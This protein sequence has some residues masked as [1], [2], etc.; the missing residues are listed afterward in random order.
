MIPRFSYGNVVL[1]V[2]LTAAIVWCML[3]GYI[4]ATAFLGMALGLTIS[5]IMEDLFYYRVKRK[6]L[7]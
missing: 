2:I 3:V 5:A 1:A 6:A 7:R 4:V